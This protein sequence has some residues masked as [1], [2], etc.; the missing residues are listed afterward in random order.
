M[1][2]KVLIIAGMHR[3]GTSL[4]TQWLYRCGLDVG[5]KLL[6]SG[7]GNAEG[8]FEDM[9]FLH[10][11]QQFLIQ[12]NLP[13]TGFVD[14]PF[15]P[16]TDH[17]KKQLKTLLES[18]SIENK[19]WGWKEPRTCLFLD[20]YRELVPSA[21]YLVIVRD[22][23][24]TINS[25][26]AREFKIHLAKFNPGKG[27]LG[28]L[29]WMLFKRKALRRIY[30]LHAEFFLR[31][32]IHYYEQIL[33]LLRSLPA[34]RYI[35]AHYTSLVKDDTAVLNR[36]KTE[37]RFSLEHFPFSSVYK[38]ELLSKPRN[39]GP[40]I[41]DKTLIQKARELEKECTKFMVS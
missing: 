32:W 40:Y 23:N 33:H 20:A 7:I 12:R 27:G 13:D 36:L 35:I 26:L 5:E 14:K 25:L 3:S 21:F 22:V 39:I 17:E 11:H 41:K 19:E 1:I 8:H 4:I 15:S 16:L 28:R 10:I 38:K 29:K 34:E 2:S 30:K 6:S 37:W 31:V 9:D 24:S 18:K